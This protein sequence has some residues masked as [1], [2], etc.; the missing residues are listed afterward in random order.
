MDSSA[1]CPLCLQFLCL[2]YFSQ[3][4]FA[5]F[6]FLGLEVGKCWFVNCKDQYM[7]TLEKGVILPNSRFIQDDIWKKYINPKF[8]FSSYKT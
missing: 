6:G 2:K 4:S 8:R 1:I 3:F 7:H 5:F